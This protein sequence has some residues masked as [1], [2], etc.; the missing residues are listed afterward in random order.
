MKKITRIVP[1]SLAK[2]LG[3]LYAIMGFVGGVIFSLVSLVI[4]ATGE[5]GGWFGLVA[6]VLLPVF[7]GI[8]GFV[9]GYITGWL[10]NFIAKRTGGIEFEI[11]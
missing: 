9:F 10:Y 4:A 7:Y 3:A 11:E 8:M 1:K 5:A 6:I 2:V